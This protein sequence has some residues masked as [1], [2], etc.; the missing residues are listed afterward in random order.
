MWIAALNGVLVSW[1]VFFQG[2]LSVAHFFNPY[3]KAL[4]AYGQFTTLDLLSYSG[5]F[6]LP[7][8]A[9]VRNFICSFS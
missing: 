3:H 9:F 1:F 4:N 6:S 7:L 5:V 2:V 8:K